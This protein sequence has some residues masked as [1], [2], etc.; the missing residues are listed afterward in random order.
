MLHNE[1]HVSPSI[2]FEYTRSAVGVNPLT[3]SEVG[4]SVTS[5]DDSD[6]AVLVV[7]MVG[8]VGAAVVETFVDVLDDDEDDS[9]QL[10]GGVGDLLKGS[11][12]TLCC[13]SG[14]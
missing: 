1:V 3:S 8:L 12:L 14:G 9:P 13:L 5:L 6:V 2:N 4:A 10:V 7:S 11:F